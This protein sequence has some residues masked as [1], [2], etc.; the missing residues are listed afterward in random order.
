MA[1][2]RIGA[3]GA[4]SARIRSTSFKELLLHAIAVLFETFV[5][6]PGIARRVKK[7][8]AFKDV[9]GQR[10]TAWCLAQRRSWPGLTRLQSAVQFAQTRHELRLLLFEHFNIAGSVSTE[11]VLQTREAYPL[12][13]TLSWDFF[14]SPNTQMALSAL[15]RLH[16]LAPSHCGGSVPY[17]ADDGNATY[18]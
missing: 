4:S 18:F 2:V 7:V 17:R 14:R 15:H 10:V 13:Y 1:M 16:G 6:A 12:G 9:V 3:C 8:E 5:I 11:Q